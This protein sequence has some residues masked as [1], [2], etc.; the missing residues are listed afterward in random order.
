MGRVI[1]IKGHTDL[2]ICFHIRNIVFILGQNVPE[3]L[4]IDGLDGQADHYL[5]YVND[6]AM[7]TARVRLTT[8]NKAKIERVAI[9]PEYQG[10][11]YGSELVGFIIADLRQQGNSN[12]VILGAQLKAISFYQR[13]GFTAF[14]EVFL[15]AGIEHRMMNLDF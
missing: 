5:I 10:H 1:K 14:G 3:N 13:L 8:E 9:L 11:G 6:V 7:G 4:E 12:K 15:D 2:T